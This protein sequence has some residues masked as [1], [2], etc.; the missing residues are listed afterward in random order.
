VGGGSVTFFF[1]A[2]SVTVD[3]VPLPQADIDKG[4][5]TFRNVLSN[6]TIS[7]SGAG[8]K[9]SLSVGVDVGGG[10]GKIEYSVNGSP[11]APYTGA[12]TMQ[13][14]SS[15]TL[16]AVAD[17]GYVF[18]EWWMGATVYSESVVSFSDV[19]SS[20]GLD[21]FFAEANDESGDFPWLVVGIVLV[22]VLFVVICAVVLLM[23]KP[24]T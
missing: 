21:L 4:Y 17:N 11:F 13:A 1:S 22:V 7:A 12:I 19:T 15:L 5:Y 2:A 3:G 20:M 23:R 9:A 18:K 6:H 14:G 24:T 10:K 16:R 8:S